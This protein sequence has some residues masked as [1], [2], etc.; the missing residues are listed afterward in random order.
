MDIFKNMLLV[1][2]DDGCREFNLKQTVVINTLFEQMNGLIMLENRDKCNVRSWVDRK[3]MD[4]ASKW[5]CGGKQQYSCM[6]LV[7]NWF[8]GL[9]L[10]SEVPYKTLCQTRATSDVTGSPFRWFQIIQSD[11]D[12]SDPYRHAVFPIST[13]WIS[14]TICL[15]IPAKGHLLLNKTFDVWSSLSLYVDTII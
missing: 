1:L 4:N 12:R 6:P 10:L 14:F 11:S 9:C 5:T 15:L 7:L 2:V 3:K 8:S 13:L